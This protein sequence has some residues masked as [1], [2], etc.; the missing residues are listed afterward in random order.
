M[1]DYDTTLYVASPIVIGKS[2]AGGAPTRIRLSNAGTV[3]NSESWANVSHVE[4][5]YTPV[6]VILDRVGDQFGNRKVTY[7]AGYN[8]T[9]LDAGGASGRLRTVTASTALDDNIDGALIFNGSSLTA[10]LP[11]PA[12]VLVGRRFTVKNLHSTALT[13]VSAGT[14]VTLDGASS[15]SLAQ[16]GKATYVTNGSTWFTV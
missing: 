2:A 3:G 16:W 9:I 15:Q 12:T 11:S 13:V 7:P 1:H 14:S 5:T 6:D 10:T 4:F 8:A